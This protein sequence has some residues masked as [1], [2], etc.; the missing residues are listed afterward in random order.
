MTLPQDTIEKV[1]KL[2]FAKYY[3]QYLLDELALLQNRTTT[4][5]AD[6]LLFAMYEQSIRYGAKCR[7]KQPKID[8]AMAA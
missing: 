5:T 8:E 6:R 7:R 3:E 4:I 1:S 2:Y